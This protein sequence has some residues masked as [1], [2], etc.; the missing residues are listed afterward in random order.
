MLR[1]GHY[2]GYHHAFKE[3]AMLEQIKAEWARLNPKFVQDDDGFWLTLWH[4]S[5][6]TLHGFFA[7]VVGCLFS[8]SS[9]SCS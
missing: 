9:G 7:M 2:S 5:K 4:A 6:E 8:G 3:L 1:I